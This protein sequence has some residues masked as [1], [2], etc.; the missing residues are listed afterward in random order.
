MIDLRKYGLESKW[1]KLT[2]LMREVSDLERRRTEVEG[3]VM[4][5][6]NAIPA[7]RDKDA[8]IRLQ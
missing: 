5:A 2:A 8:D 4:A 3:Q 6:R 1:P 7:A